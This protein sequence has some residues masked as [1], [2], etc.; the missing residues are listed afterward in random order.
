MKRSKVNKVRDLAPSYYQRDQPTRTTN[1][2]PP[3]HPLTPPPPP[4]HELMSLHTG[5]V[6]ALNY[7]NCGY[8]ICM[9]KLELS[10]DCYNCQFC[11]A[12]TSFTNAT[13][14]IVLLRK[15]SLDC[16]SAFLFCSL[17]ICMSFC[18]SARENGSEISLQSFSPDS[19][20]QAGRQAGR[21]CQGCN[22]AE[23]KQSSVLH[24]TSPLI[25]S[26]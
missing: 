19:T 2:Q 11:A 20:L 12:N 10:L 4:T 26:S 21:Q 14:N 9:K 15:R 24:I 23:C 7:L 5:R 3:I 6:P 18:P 13:L 8:S 22:L 16:P 1:H 17:S 25:F